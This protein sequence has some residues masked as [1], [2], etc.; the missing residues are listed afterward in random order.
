MGSS[1]WEVWLPLR[2]KQQCHS[3]KEPTDLGA[4]L[5]CAHFLLNTSVNWPLNSPAFSSSDS[6]TPLPFLLLRGGI[7]WVSFLT[8]YVP[9]EA[10]MSTTKL[11]TYKSCCFLTSAFISPLKV[12]NFDLKFTTASLFL[13]CMC[14]ISSTNLPSYLRVIRTSAIAKFPYVNKTMW[15]SIRK[16]FVTNSAIQVWVCRVWTICPFPK[17][18]AQNY[19]HWKRERESSNM[20]FSHFL[21]S[22]SNKTSNNPESELAKLVNK[23]GGEGTLPISLGKEAINICISNGGLKCLWVLISTTPSFGNKV[24]CWYTGFTFETF[25]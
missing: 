3:W 16:H 23:G 4:G 22:N 2:P 18:E 25:I 17:N 1:L 24:I 5:G 9:I 20:K 12:S 21:L 10:L 19:H 6:A 13:F 8:I 14:L 11:L 7:P 15:G